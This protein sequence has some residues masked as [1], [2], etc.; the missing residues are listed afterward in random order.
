MLACVL[1]VL[2][3]FATRGSLLEA[4]G[5]LDLLLLRILS[6]VGRRGHIQVSEC[7]CPGRRL[8]WRPES[9]VGEEA[10]AEATEGMDRARCTGEAVSQIACRRH[11]SVTAAWSL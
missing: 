5:A 4:F 6:V 11:T 8:R 2:F 3:H 10:I 9:D 7:R 1:L